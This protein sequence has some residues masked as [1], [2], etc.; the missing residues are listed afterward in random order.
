MQ[1]GFVGTGEITS[2]MVTGLSSSDAELR[3]IRLSPRNLEVAA[4]LANRFPNV[5]IASS[6]QDV[7]DHCD[8]V[9]IAVR[10]Q[11]AGSVLS[12]LRFRPGHCVISVRVRAFVAESVGVRRTC[13]AHH[14]SRTAAINR[15]TNRSDGNL[16]A[17]PVRGGSFCCHRN[18]VCPRN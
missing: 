16:S 17:G 11:V 12:E 13:N 4:H 14:K 1:L 15:P 10:P 5:S 3:S 2:A 18:C 7:L 8:T 9:M 6:N